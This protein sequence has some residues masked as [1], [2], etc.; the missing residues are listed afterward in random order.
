LIDPFPASPD[1]P[2]KAL[3]CIVSARF[4]MTACIQLLPR[5][6]GTLF[7]RRLR[8]VQ[9]GATRFSAARISKM[10]SFH[11]EVGFFSEAA[12]WGAEASTPRNKIVP[13]LILPMMPELAKIAAVVFAGLASIVGLAGGA[14]AAGKIKLAQTS[15]VTICMM[16]CNSAYAFC[17][18][19]CVNPT[20]TRNMLDQ[21]T[22]S[23]GALSGSGS[24]VSLCTT[25]QLTCQTTCARTSPSP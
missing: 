10:N 3:D 18:S 11:F 23:A 19:S 22:F 2:R 8:W 20:Q 14:L 4:A 6:K 1:R 7:G 17:Q 16:N 9:P 21:G 12:L 15:T 5:R 13:L 25:Q 24:C